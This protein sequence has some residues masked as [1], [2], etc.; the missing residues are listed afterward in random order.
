MTVRTDLQ[1]KVSGKLRCYAH[2][3]ASTRNESRS[4][5]TSLPCR[6]RLM[7]VCQTYLNVEN[8]EVRK[9]IPLA[10]GTRA[11]ELQTGDGAVEHDAT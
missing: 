4:R 5:A 8:A 10:P 3:R 7:A 11:H 9:I 2:R 1:V 6:A